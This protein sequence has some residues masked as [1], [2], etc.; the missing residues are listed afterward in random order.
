MTKSVFDIGLL[1]NRGMKFYTQKLL[2]KIALVILTIL[3]TS[4]KCHARHY[5]KEAVYQDYWCSQRN[6]TQEYKLPDNSR[7][8][9]LLPDYAVEFD[10]AKK[11]DECLGQALRYSSYTKKKAACCLI[12]E[13][14]KDKKYLNQLRYTV[15]KKGLDVSVFTITPSALIKAGILSEYLQ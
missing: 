3:L 10:F 4:T 6:G 1:Y 13:T 2:T 12:I 9:C 14:E 15:R 11:R 5:Y 7:V 8:D